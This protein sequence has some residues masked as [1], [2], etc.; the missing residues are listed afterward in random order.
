MGYDSLQDYEDDDTVEYGDADRLIMA[1]FFPGSQV[2][3]PT[4]E[5]SAVDSGRLAAERKLRYAERSAAEA[6]EKL[7]WLDSLPKEPSFD[8][9]RPVVIYFQKQFNVGGRVYDYAALKAP[10]GLW[11]TT[12]PKSP[13]GFTWDQLIEWLST[14]TYARGEDR[15]VMPVIYVARKLREL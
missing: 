13:K 15:R 4:D 7:E 1:A 14:L 3:Y 2:A 10:D 12:G 6:L 9:D 11:Y 5:T 8:D